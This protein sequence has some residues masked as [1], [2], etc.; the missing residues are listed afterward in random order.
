MLAEWEAADRPTQPTPAPADITVSELCRAFKRHA[1]AQY[2]LSDGST[3]GEIHP[4]KAAVKALRLL[5]GTIPAVDF[6]PLAFK[7]LRQWWIDRRLSRGTINRYCDRV[8]RVFAWGAAEQLVP[9]AV[10][11]TLRE[12]AGLRFGRSEARE[13][14][15]IKP[16]DDATVDATLPHLPPVVADMV[17][18]QRLTGCRPGELCILRPADV[19]TS[20]ETWLY[21]PFRHKTAHR[22][23]E[24]VIAIGPKGQDVLRPYLL[25]PSDAFCFSPTD[26]ERKRRDARHEARKTPLDQGNAPGTNR[27]RKPARHAGERYTPT[28]YARAIVRGCEV[29]FGMP[30]QFRNIPKLIPDLPGEAQEAERTKLQRLAAEW[31]AEHCWSPNQLRHTYATEVRNRLG[32]EATQA[33]LGHAHA[34]VTQIYAERNLS[35][36]VQ[37]AKLVG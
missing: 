11:H 23:K 36:A 16:V 5:Y 6:G 27:K 7:A 15:P 1:V 19:D 20:G 24:R 29:A 21:R 35:L 26:S 33:A 28:S 12:V 25:R 8:R 14:E 3:S 18:L 34:D 37:A 9:P 13:S 2:R 4:I 10:V 32:L 31:R 30:R 17:R 22:G